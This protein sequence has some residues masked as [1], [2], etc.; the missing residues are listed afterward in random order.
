MVGRVVGFKE[1]DR[2]GRRVGAWD[3][4]LVGLAEGAAVWEVGMKVGTCRGWDSVW[5]VGGELGTD[6]D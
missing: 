5:A 1:G 2:V 4:T 6:T 3:G